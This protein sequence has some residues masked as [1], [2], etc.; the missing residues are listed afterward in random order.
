MN[1]RK[2]KP[3]MLPQMFESAHLENI[4]RSQRLIRGTRERIHQ[5]NELMQDTKGIVASS[6]ERKGKQ[7]SKQ[8]S[9]HSWL[10]RALAEAGDR[11]AFMTYA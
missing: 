7:A 8:A 1:V 10:T 2:A 6:K 9:K 3:Y 4:A 11:E 5:S